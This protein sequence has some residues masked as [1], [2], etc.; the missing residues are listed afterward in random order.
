MFITD[1][2]GRQRKHAEKPNAFSAVVYLYDRFNKGPLASFIALF[3]SFLSPGPRS[4]VTSW[5]SLA[6]L[7]AGFR[8]LRRSALMHFHCLSMA[9]YQLSLEHTVR[10]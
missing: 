10:R 5:L 1:L 4:T 8:L 9:R 6:I 2:F 3:L 7:T